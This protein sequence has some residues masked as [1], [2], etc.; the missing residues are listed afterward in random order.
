MFTQNIYQLK[1]PW[2][3]IK[4]TMPK[5]INKQQFNIVVNIFPQETKNRYIRNTVKLR[6]NTKHH[7]HDPLMMTLRDA[8]TLK[9]TREV[10]NVTA[11]DT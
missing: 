5:E 2:C 11:D 6:V 8:V 1:T 7:L 10:I 4:I 3:Y 9:Q